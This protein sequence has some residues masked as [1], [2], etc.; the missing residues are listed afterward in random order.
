MR[1]IKCSKCGIEVE[2]A[3]HIKKATCFDCKK[4]ANLIRNRKA[5]K[6]KK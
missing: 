1:F 6:L 3:N 2:R 5:Y 4:N